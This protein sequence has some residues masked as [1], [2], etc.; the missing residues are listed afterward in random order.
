MYLIVTPEWEGPVGNRLAAVRR[1]TP[2]GV[3]IH[4]Y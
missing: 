3:F 1:F 2:L 4:V